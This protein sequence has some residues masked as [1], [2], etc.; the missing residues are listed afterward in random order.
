MQTFSA[1]IDN[2]AK[3]IYAYELALYADKGYEIWQ[4]EPVE[5]RIARGGHPEDLTGIALEDNART[6]KIGG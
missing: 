1:R 6:M 5:K 2:T 3:I 4:E